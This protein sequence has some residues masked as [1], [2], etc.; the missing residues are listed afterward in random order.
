LVTGWTIE[1]LAAFI[2]E[3]YQVD[4]ENLATLGKQ[5]LASIYQEIQLEELI[6]KYCEVPF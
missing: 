4:L 1:G 2:G 5:T 6:E 3:K